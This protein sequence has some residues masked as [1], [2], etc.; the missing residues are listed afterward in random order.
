V[1]RRIPDGWGRWI[2]CDAGWYAILVD[3]DA[4]L[5]RLDP[6]YTVLQIKEKF[7]TLRFY[8]TTQAADNDARVRFDELVHRA[9]RES[10]ATC[11]RCG[12]PGVLSSTRGGWY[13]TLCGRCADE[14][15]ASGGSTYRP[16]HRER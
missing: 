12:R 10:A 15:V 2:D 11:E 16:M 3:L 6:D 9:E 8:C 7:G 1:L 14:P 5:S 4:K 13:K